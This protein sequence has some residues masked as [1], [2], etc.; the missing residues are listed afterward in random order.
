MEARS[1]LLCGR[2]RQFYVSGTMALLFYLTLLFIVA[3]GY[4][5]LRLASNRFE[6]MLQVKLSGTVTKR[7]LSPPPRVSSNENLIDNLAA[8]PDATLVNPKMASWGQICVPRSIQLTRSLFYVSN[9]TL[10]FFLMLGT[11]SP[12]ST[13]LCCR[14]DNYN[15][16]CVFFVQSR[17]DL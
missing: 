14:I 17:H 12:L 4:E 3:V 8:S 13:I 16:M 1:N 6:R 10:S 11:L 9:V 15:L 5:Y 7:P 2:F